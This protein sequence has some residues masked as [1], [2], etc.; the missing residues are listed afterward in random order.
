MAEGLVKPVTTAYAN[1]TKRIDDAEE[2]AVSSP[3]APVSTPKA[4]AGPAITADAAAAK[5][6]K[7]KADREAFDAEAKK[8]LVKPSLLGRVKAAV[9]LD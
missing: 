7:Y 5:S 8:G 6:A 4:D 3:S 9:G 1:R 2:A